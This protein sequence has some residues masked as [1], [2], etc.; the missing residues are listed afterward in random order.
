MNRLA[1][2]RRRLFEAVGPTLPGRVEAY[3][4]AFV[5]R[6]TAPYIWIEQPSGGVASMAAGGRVFVATFPVWCVYDGAVRA[7]VAGLDGIVAA[8]WDACEAAEGLEPRSVT[9]RDVTAAG[10][11]LRGGEPDTLHLRASVVTVAVTITAR[12]F[13][14]P[15]DV[16]PASIPPVLVEV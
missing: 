7:Q 8:V 9:P 2:A 13:C 11:A 10:E 3:P 12:T 4:Q 16:V 15:D 1:E 14:K 6:G 5:A